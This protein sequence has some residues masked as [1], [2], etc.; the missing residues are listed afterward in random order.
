MPAKSEV[1]S[2]SHRRF[3]IINGD[4]F[5]ISSGVNRAIIEAYQR[6]V[7]TSTS[8]MV[9]G[10]AFDEAV[11]LAQANPK[12]AVGLHLVLGR[13]QAVLPPE[14]IPHLVDS[15]GNFSDRVNLAGIRYH[16]SP[17]ARRE[18]PLEIRAQLE[19]FRSTG[20]QLS[21]VDGHVDMHLNPIALHALVELALE[22]DIK[23]IRLPCEELRMNLN[24]DSRNLLTKLAW[25]VIMRGLHRY[26]KRL[27]KSKGISFPERVYGWLQGGSMTEEYLLGLIPE[28]CADYVEIFSHPKV[29]LAQE[30]TNQ[31]WG[32]GEAELE[33]L[34][35][36]NVRE[37]IVKSGFELT[38][39]NQ[40]VPLLMN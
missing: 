31:S 23:V 11:A 4:D 35:S 33:A 1:S 39:Y 26:G 18:L 30:Q 21:H 38:N 22:F 5:G 14:K 40:R 25:S 37:V 6:G 17:G 3:L 15:N 7:L 29:T 16:L 27:L 28:I 20:L 2:Q 19:K 24:L 12:L 8:L 32:M 36:H 34:L 10:K 9:A 13:G